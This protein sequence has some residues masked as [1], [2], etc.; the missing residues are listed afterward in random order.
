MMSFRLLSSSP[1]SPVSEPGRVADPPR[2][3]LVGGAEDL[4]AL[5]EEKEVLRG[6][7]QMHGVN[8]EAASVWA[9][10]GDV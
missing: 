5:L 6:G 10:C 9:V 7:R 8:L 2:G 3:V 4:A 1:P